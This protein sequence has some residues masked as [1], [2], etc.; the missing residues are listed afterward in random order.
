M[1]PDNCKI[2]KQDHSFFCLDFS[3]HYK[4]YQEAIKWL[5]KYPDKT[6]V[7][8]TI[9]NCYSKIGDILSEEADY[10]GALANYNAAPN[11]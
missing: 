4:Y 1:L 8:K 10:K 9:A 3:V 2:R 5:S 6:E 7:I 11:M